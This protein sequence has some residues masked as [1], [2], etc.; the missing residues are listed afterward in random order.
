M[1][2]AKD[3]DAIKYLKQ[4]LSDTRAEMAKFRK[5]HLQ[6]RPFDANA[7]LQ[8]A[9]KLRKL[10]DTLAMADELQFYTDV[11]GAAVRLCNGTLHWRGKHASKKTTR[12]RN[13]PNG[14]R[15]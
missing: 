10:T 7:V 9:V 11:I 4:L 3:E 14:V 15:S 6:G 2:W 13:I 1:G 8:E 12:G 5:L